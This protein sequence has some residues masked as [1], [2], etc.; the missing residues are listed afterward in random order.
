MS[1]VRNPIALAIAAAIA[2]ALLLGVLAGHD[3][4]QPRHAAT[5]RPAAKPELSE[6]D[7]KLTAPRESAGRQTARRFLHAFA[8]Y[9]IAASTPHVRRALRA[10]STPALAASLL[11]RPPRAVHGEHPDRRAVLGELRLADASQHS[12]QYRAE[13]DRGQITELFSLLLARTAAGDWR[14]AQVSQ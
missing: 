4:Y 1:R 11:A 14:V 10:T 9:E 7:D 5:T 3:P 8:E 13:L 6:R 12:L 2:A